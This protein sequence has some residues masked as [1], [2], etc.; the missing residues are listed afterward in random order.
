MC[1]LCFPLIIDI[2]AGNM[3]C[4]VCGTY[5]GITAIQ[6]DVKTAVEA[7]VI[8]EALNLAKYGRHA[9]L[10]KMDAACKDIFGGLVPR[11]TMKSTAPRVE[12]ITYDPNRKRD[13]IGPGGS[14]LRQLQ[15]RF[16][17]SLDLSQD[18][19]CCE[20]LYFTDF[21]T[22]CSTHLILVPSPLNQ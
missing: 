10:R 13:L 12:V 7:Q 14:V 2:C 3:D 19:R 17:V 1:T 6:C 5:G 20:C 21:F 4:K 18:G 9:I 8:I 22:Y 16:N 11:T 15:D